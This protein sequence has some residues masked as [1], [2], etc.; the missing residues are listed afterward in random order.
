MQVIVHSQSLRTQAEKI[1]IHFEGNPDDILI[2]PSAFEN[3]RLLKKDN[4]WIAIDI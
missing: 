1:K 4:Y 3:K 2:V